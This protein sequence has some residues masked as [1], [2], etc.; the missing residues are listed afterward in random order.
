MA[1][2]TKEVLAVEPEEVPG[3]ICSSGAMFQAK[4][5]RGMYENFWSFNSKKAYWALQTKLGGSS[6]ATSFP[7]CLVY[8]EKQDF[9]QFIQPTLTL[10]QSRDKWGFKQLT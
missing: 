7:P 2:G 4:D 8:M 9:K 5:G 10:H 3:S 6:K 1:E